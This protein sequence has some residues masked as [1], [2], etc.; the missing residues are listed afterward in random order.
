M[1]LVPCRTSGDH[2]TDYARVETGGGDQSPLCVIELKGSASRGSVLL[3]E[4]LGRS[5]KMLGHPPAKRATLVPRQQ[6][7]RTSFVCARS[8]LKKVFVWGPKILTV[9]MGDGVNP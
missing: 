5:Q 3:R 9:T 2:V 1:L 7:L 8:H 6:R 4:S